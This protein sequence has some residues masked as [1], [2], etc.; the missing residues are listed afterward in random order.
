[1]RIGGEIILAFTPPISVVIFWLILVQ[2]HPPNLIKSDSCNNLL[3][4]RRQALQKRDA[5]DNESHFTNVPYTTP[6]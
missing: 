1:M 6:N 5:L 2:F 3:D 4:R